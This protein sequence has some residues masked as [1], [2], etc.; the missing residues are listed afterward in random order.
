[1]GSQSSP[2]RITEFSEMPNHDSTM[3]DDLIS[4]RITERVI[5]MAPECLWSYLH[6]SIQQEISSKLQN[7]VKAL[8]MVIKTSKEKSCLR[9]KIDP[10]ESPSLYIVIRGNLI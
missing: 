5:I 7:V 1:V 6:S 2:Y 8:T 3:G 9:E 10:S 4:L